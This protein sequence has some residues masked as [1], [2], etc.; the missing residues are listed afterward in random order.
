MPLNEST[1]QM[2]FA[3]KLVKEYGYSKSTVK[4]EFPIQMGSYNARADVVILNKNTLSF[5]EDIFF[6]AEIKISGSNRD[7][8]YR[9]LRSYIAASLNC[10][11]AALVIGSII[12]FFVVEELNGRKTLKRIVSLPS[13]YGSEYSYG[14]TKDSL[15]LTGS[16]EETRDNPSQDKLPEG[17]GCGCIVAIIFG[18]IYIIA[19]IGGAFI[20]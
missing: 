20:K 8:A 2:A 11:Y 4:T 5:Q 9:Q 3:E 10:K 6:I 18:I 1:I 14:Q 7:T 19:W 12:E 15:L 17:C 13:S 16:A